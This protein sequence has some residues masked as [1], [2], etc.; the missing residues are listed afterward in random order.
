MTPIDINDLTT[1]QGKT[2]RQ[3]FMWE[4]KPI[5]RKPI[6]AISLAGGS[7]VLTA[8]GHGAVNGQH[9]RHGRSGAPKVA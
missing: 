2:F 6:T 9:E 4:S 1:L 5:V 3:P 8:A 7:P